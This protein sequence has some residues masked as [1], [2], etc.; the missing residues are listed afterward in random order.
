MKAEVRR[1]EAEGMMIVLP[2]EEW[3]DFGQMNLILIENH[4]FLPKGLPNKKIPKLFLVEW[5]S[6]PS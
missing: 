4:L 1:Q 6:S 3:Q 5:A 2:R